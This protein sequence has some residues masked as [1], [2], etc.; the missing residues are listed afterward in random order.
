MKGEQEVFRFLLKN[1]KE[2][3]K[4]STYKLKRYNKRKEQ[5]RV[6]RLFNQD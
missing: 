2:S 1:E 4:A 5:N 3:L 6:N